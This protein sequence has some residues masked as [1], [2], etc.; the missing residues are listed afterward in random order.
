V[1]V[2]ASAIR[3]FE[4]GAYR[5]KG[6]FLDEDYDAAEQIAETLNTARREVEAGEF[7]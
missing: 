6:G 2:P 5:L 4:A 7:G 3:C 1:Y